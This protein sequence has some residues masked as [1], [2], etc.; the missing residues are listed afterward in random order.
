MDTDAILDELGILPGINEVIVTT[1]R[2][3]VPNAAPIGI[4]R[5]ESITVRL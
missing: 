2:D 4:I 1:E 5:G 3:G